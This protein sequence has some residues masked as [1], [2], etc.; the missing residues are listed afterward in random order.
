[1]HDFL[2][3]HWHEPNGDKRAG[4]GT[5]SR[6]KTPYDLFMENEGVPIFRDIGIGNVR[7]L[8]LQPWKRMGGNASFIQLTGTESKW[9]SFVVE[10]PGRG[11]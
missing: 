2:K 4:F 11:V 10:V 1:M 5:F 8:P 9:G 7:N 6:V 3:P